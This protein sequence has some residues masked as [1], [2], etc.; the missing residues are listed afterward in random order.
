MN[1]HLNTSKIVKLKKG[2]FKLYFVK[3]IQKILFQNHKK[4]VDSVRSFNTRAS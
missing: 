2:V 4:L 3:C 1:Y